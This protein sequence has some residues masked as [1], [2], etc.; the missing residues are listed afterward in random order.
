MGSAASSRKM[1]GREIQLVLPKAEGKRSMQL[2]PDLVLL[3]V[4]ANG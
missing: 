4:Q 1:E 2:A 3:A